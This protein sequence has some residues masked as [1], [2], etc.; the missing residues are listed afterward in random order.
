[1]EE[2]QQKQQISIAYIHTV[3]SHAGYK[4]VVDPVDDDSVDVYVSAKGLV[5]PHLKIRSPM[6]SLQLKCSSRDLLRP[7]HLAYDLSKKN[8]NDLRIRSALPRYL[9]LL[10]LPADPSHWL[11]QDEERMVS[12]GCAYYHSLKNEPESANETSKTIHIP[13]TQRFNVG[14]LENLM[15]LASKVRQK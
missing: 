10:L 15:A 14:S 6:I 4:V 3:A 13:R 8:H 7:S 11:E 2:N 12:R 9:V 5:R 1:M